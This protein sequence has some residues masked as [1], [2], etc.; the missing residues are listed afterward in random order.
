MSAVGSSSCGS[1]ET[2]GGAVFKVTID[3][4][5]KT[6]ESEQ[7]IPRLRAEPSF[8]V[9]LW[10]LCEEERSFSVNNKSQI[11]DLK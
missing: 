4:S 6:R 8:T 10:H 2:G 11:T 1:F 5:E 9:H 3:N 7:V